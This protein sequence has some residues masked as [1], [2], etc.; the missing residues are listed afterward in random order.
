M[1]ICWNCSCSTAWG[2]ARFAFYAAPGS[3]TCY[4]DGQN[5]MF[6]TLG[7]L[8]D[9]YEWY[10]DAFLARRAMPTDVTLAL[11]VHAIDDATYQLGAYVCL[12]PT[13]AAKTVRVHMVQALDHWSYPGNARNRY[14]NHVDPID[15]TLSPGDCHTLMGVFPL[16]EDSILQRSDIK[17]IA[18]AQE[19]QDVGGPAD[20]AEVFQA[21]IIEYPF[22]MDCNA[23]GVPDKTDI[24]LGLSQDLNMNGVP[25]E[26][27]FIYAGTDVW[28][29]PPGGTTF[30]DFDENAIPP[31]FFGPGS[32]P[33]DGKITFGGV[34]LTS[35]PNGV[36]FP[37]DTVIERLDYMVLPEVSDV[38]TV[39]IE[40]V[41]LSLASVDPIEVTY[42]G[43]QT[44]ELWDVHVCLSDVGQDIGSMVAR[45]DCPAGGTYDALLPVRPK[46]TFVRQSDQAVRVLD[47]GVAG[48]PPYDL[49]LL[50]GVWVEDP[51]ASLDLINALPSTQVDGNCDGV[52]DRQLLGASNFAPGVWPVYCEPNQPTTLQRKRLMPYD[53]AGFALGLIAAQ[54][55]GPDGDDDG[56]A[57]DADNCLA[58]SNPSQADLDWDG[59]GDECDACPDAWNPLQED[60]DGDGYADA[61]DNCPWHFNPDQLDTDGDGTGDVCESSDCPGDFDCDGD[62][63]YFDISYLLAALNSEQ[64]WA[65]YYASQHGGEPPPCN[66]DINCDPD[67]Q[68]DGMTYFDIS[69]FIESL[70]QS[71]TPR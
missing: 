6:G 53:G 40:I 24:D 47:T 62:R 29:T 20:R 11:S 4:V 69:P 63:D 21:A 22:P 5:E 59:V 31:D 36:L 33:F 26:C 66:Y 23:N 50:D 48:W 27:E 19:P 71:C 35:D 2:D 64:E 65:D 51:D 39:P 56:I 52:W 58:L 41:A 37:A 28:T 70:G 1:Q 17:F 12:E 42:N 45:R 43:G 32:D 15:I 60:T 61:C 18:W 14:K 44:S 46:F 49:A 54:I 68:G 16:D 7:S 57:D 13:G 55:P 3:P 10:R 38:D 8:Q 34:P 67:G 25:D 30:S 9:Q